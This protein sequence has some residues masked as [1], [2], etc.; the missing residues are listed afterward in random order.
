LWFFRKI[1]NDPI[2]F[3]ISLSHL[4]KEP[5][6]SFEQFLI[7]FTQE[8]FVTSFIEIGMLVLEKIFSI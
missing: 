7:F 8:R 5:D 2:P 1:L 3:F 6:P 4:G